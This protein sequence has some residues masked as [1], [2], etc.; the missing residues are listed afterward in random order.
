MDENAVVEAVCRVYQQRGYK[1][2]QRLSTTEHGIDI[3]AEHAETKHRFLV[4]AKGS[5]SSREGSARFGKP[6][7]QTQV[8]DRAAKGVYT[9][10]QLR[11]E[12][13]S[14]GGT[15]VVLAVPD[16]KWFRNYLEPVSSQ[17]AA[18]GIELLFV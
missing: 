8:F 12:N 5:T 7:T 16:E 4:E 18:L 9:C 14:V 13:P 11:A 1:I 6:Y 3:I 10:I 15:T 17:L 2:M